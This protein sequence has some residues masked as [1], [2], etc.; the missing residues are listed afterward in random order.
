[1][2]I[3]PTRRRQLAAAVVAL[4]ALGA[5][6]PAAAGAQQQQQ[7]SSTPL[8]APALV[9]SNVASSSVAPPAAAAVAG[10]S[11]ADGAA[12]AGALRPGD[13]VRV[14]IWREPDLSGDFPVDERGVAVFPR[15]GPVDVT[16][17][18]PDS[19][20]RQ[21]VTGYQV[22]LRN[23]S[24]EVVPLRRVMVGGAVYHP[25]VFTVDPSTT[26]ADAIALAGGVTP[27]GR[28]NRVRVMRGADLVT[29]QLG[30]RTRIGDSAVRSGDQIF[31][32]E[33]SWLVRNGSLVLGSVTTLLAVVSFMRR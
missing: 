22:Y 2:T 14:R 20:Q 15:L 3:A 19:L 23:P 11:A 12:P 25:G 27:Q 17:L 31:V 30:V 8:A 21:L 4:G 7:S 10:S 29:T 9:T 5:I 32:P 18:S 1:M 16:R 6:S 26:V 13:V 33:R 24:I 28:P